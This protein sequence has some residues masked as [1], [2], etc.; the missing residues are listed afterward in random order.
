MTEQTTSDH[1]SRAEPPSGAAVGF[2]MF[3]GVL[4]IMVGSF[5]AFVGLVGILE[6]EFYAA[7]PNYILELDA[8]TWGWVHL[9]VGLLVAFAGY[10]VLSGKTWG[11]V[12]GVTL[13]VLSALANF[14]FIPLYPFWSITVIA[15]NVA[16]IWAL[17]AHGRDITRWE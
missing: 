13:A 8:T 6:N 17:T 16:V 4:M 7:T 11:R 9:L 3:A 15:L 10:A 12:I 2:T 1:G 5:Q 14:V